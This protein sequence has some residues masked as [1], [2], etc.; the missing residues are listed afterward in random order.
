MRSSGLSSRH[1]QDFLQSS[2][3]TEHLELEKAV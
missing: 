3:V 2:L 1:F